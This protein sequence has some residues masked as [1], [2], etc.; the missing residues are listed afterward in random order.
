[1]NI[2]YTDVLGHMHVPLDDI[3]ACEKLAETILDLDALQEALALPGDHRAVL[4]FADHDGSLSRAIPQIPAM[5]AYDPDTFSIQAAE[6]GIISTVV[7]TARRW[8]DHF[9]AG[10]YHLRHWILAAAGL[11]SFV[12]GREARAAYDNAQTWKKFGV[13]DPE[14][15]KKVRVPAI[16]AVALLALSVM[17]K[18]TPVAIKKCLE[19]R[20]PT[21][22]SGRGDYMKKVKDIF[23]EVAQ[24]DI[25][26]LG[27]R[28]MSREDAGKSARDLGYTPDGVVKLVGEVKSAI[29]E[30]QRCNF[31]PQQLEDLSRSVEAGTSN[32]R[33]ALAWI[34]KVIAQTLHFAISDVREG[35]H[36]VK[37][38]NDD[39]AHVLQQHGHD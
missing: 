26:K 17:A 34:M 2:D 6:E 11:A 31:I 24:V 36:T 21:D 33:V 28:T 3:Y 8:L 1:M 32:G 23:Q 35:G 7:K 16:T 27:L 25:D 38:L 5:E 30:L 29:D 13:K 14:A 37:Q 10:L 12:T 15:Y 39:Y 9:Q 4:A 18:S 22:T 19:L 20:L